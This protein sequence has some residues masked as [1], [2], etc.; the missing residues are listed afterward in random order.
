MQDIRTDAF[1]FDVTDRGVGEDLTAE[2]ARVST[3]TPRD[4]G[5]RALV[6]VPPIPAG[7]GLVELE[8]ASAELDRCRVILAGAVAALAAAEARRGAA[9]N[10]DLAEGADALRRG[11]APAP[12]AVHDLELDIRGL[13]GN[14]DAARVL[15]VQCEMALDAVLAEHRAAYGRRLDAALAAD[16]DDA[17]GALDSYVG[18]R[19]VVI[20]DL[21]LAAW[22]RGETKIGVV[23]PELRGISSSDRPA[24]QHAAVVESLK[25]ELTW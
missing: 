16:R 23:L 12:S 13:V 14:R 6:K 7:L 22:L 9:R 21:A 8:T 15:V 3:P 11:A 18:A 19:N 20:A 2:L 4:L 5:R 25:R 1:E 24:P 10:A 17:L